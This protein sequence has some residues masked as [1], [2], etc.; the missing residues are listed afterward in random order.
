MRIEIPGDDGIDGVVEAFDPL[1][2]GFGQFDG[3]DLA[4]SDQPAQLGGGHVRETVH[5]II[6]RNFSTG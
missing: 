2:A 6:L 1:D 3:R 5:F 4:P